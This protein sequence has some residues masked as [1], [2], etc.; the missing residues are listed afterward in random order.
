MA[1]RNLFVVIALFLVAACGSDND[2][3]GPG[4]AGTGTMSAVING[5]S[6]SATV[7]SGTVTSG[8]ISVLGGVDAQYTLAIGWID[9]G[10]RTYVIGSDDAGFN[11]RLSLPG[12]TLADW[13]ASLN[14]GSGTMTITS[15]SSSR[16]TG[17]FSFTMPPTEHGGQTETL[18]VTDG[19]FD[20][21]S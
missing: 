11:A 8:S 17:T 9:S 2:P 5:Q 20:L 19:V 21:S 13:Q 16:I 14:Q 12:S 18:Q 4:G 3:A 6:W 1:R 15:Q 7:T 10:P